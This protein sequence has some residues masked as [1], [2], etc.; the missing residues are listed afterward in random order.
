MKRIVR[1][2][3]VLVLAA[4]TPA[5]LAQAYPSKVI[6]LIVPWAPGGS[7]DVLARLIAVKMTES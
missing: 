2:A 5:A 6:R 1:I 4:V 3:A 7:T